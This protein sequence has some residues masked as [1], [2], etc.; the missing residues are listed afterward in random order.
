[1]ELGLFEKIYAMCKTDDLELFKTIDIEGLDEFHVFNIS[2]N[3]I[4]M[5]ASSIINYII[6]E[7]KITLAVRPLINYCLKKEDRNIEEYVIT[8]IT[9]YNEIKDI[10][11]DNRTDEHKLHFLSKMFNKVDQYIDFVKNCKERN[12]EYRKLEK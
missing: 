1:M 5:G 4:N 2:T 9:D 12:I 10:W 11:F 6:D 7:N 3:A 8:H